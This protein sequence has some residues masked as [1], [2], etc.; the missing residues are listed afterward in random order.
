MAEIREKIKEV[1]AWTGLSQ[2]AFGQRIGIS[3]SSINK[4]ETGENNPSEQTIKLICQ[5]FGINYLWLTQDNG[6]MRLTRDTDDEMIDKVMIRSSNFARQTM[7][8]FARNADEEDW[9][10]LSYIV[11]KWMDGNKKADQ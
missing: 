5:E 9:E 6:D 7:K 3:G 11:K 10:L 8:D 1:R 4:L 2:R